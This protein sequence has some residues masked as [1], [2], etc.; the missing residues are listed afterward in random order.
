MAPEA[1]RLIDQRGDPLY[2]LVVSER[3]LRSL[4]YFDECDQKR[5]VE[6]QVQTHIHKTPESPESP[7]IGGFIIGFDFNNI[8]VMI[9]ILLGTHNKDILRVCASEVV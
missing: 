5:I 3:F 9:Y 8:E 2:S 4:I 1:I 6:K 7:R